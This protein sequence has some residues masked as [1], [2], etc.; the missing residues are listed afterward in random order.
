MKDRREWASQ[1]EK[2][3]MQWRPFI[4]RLKTSAR[5]I[6]FSAQQSHLDFLLG[7]RNWPPADFAI[8]SGKQIFDLLRRS[9]CSELRDDAILLLLLSSQGSRQRKVV[10]R[11]DRL[12]QVT[13][14]GNYFGNSKATPY[15]F[16][17]ERVDLQRRRDDVRG[18]LRLRHCA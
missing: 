12:A 6:N 10:V 13:F 3:F 7:D 2:V 11:R 1:M 16:A 15:R 18:V 9:D 5:V 14:L 8:P 4:R 17:N